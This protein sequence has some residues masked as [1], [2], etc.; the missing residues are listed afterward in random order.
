MANL[1]TTRK[2]NTRHSALWLTLALLLALEVLATTLLVAQITAFSTADRRDVF[3]LTEAGG[4][5]QVTVVPGPS[6]AAPGRRL[7]AVRRPFVTLANP[8]FKAYDR[9]TVW[10]AETDVEIFSVQYENDDLVCTVKSGNGD[11]VI[12]P[13]TGGSYDFSL[14]N[15]GDCS[16]DYTLTCEAWFTGTGPD[17]REVWIPVEARLSDYTGDWLVGSATEWTDVRQLNT[18]R[19]EGVIA[20][21]NV[22]DYRLDWRWPFERG[23]GETLTANDLY[24]SSLGN[25]AV[26]QD[27]QLHVRILTT[28]QMDE[29][30]TRPGGHTTPKT[31]DES[32]LVLWLVVAAVALALM[33]LLA[34]RSRRD[35][36][37]AAQ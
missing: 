21:G 11:K 15:D 29:D 7:L 20:A 26:D 33:V 34:V 24:D 36:R 10:Q 6:A 16:L 32:Q 37:E 23:E 9:N 28:A 31:G 17:G 4:G 35:R 25:L 27:L 30:P 5:T 18:V 3:S 22:W 13:G 14:A 12:A 1:A 8:S 2:Q 19:Q